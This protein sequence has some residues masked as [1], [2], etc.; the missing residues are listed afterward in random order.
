MATETTLAHAHVKTRYDLYQLLGG[1]LLS[2]HHLNP[3]KID[4]LNGKAD[5]Y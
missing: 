2:N 1:P 4:R 3:L 5:W